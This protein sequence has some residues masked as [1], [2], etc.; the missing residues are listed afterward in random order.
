MST[1]INRAYFTTISFELL[2]Q[3]QL[4]THTT[5]VYFKKFSAVDCQA[6]HVKFLGLT[7]LQVPRQQLNLAGVSM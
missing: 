1:C 3:S 6:V 4:T 7:L 5:K 2:P